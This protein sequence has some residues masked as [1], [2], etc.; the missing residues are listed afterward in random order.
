MG[1]D[2]LLDQQRLERADARGGRRLVAVGDRRVVV[3]VVVRGRSLRLLE[4]VLEDVDEEPVV[5]VAG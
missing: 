1:D 4:P 2:A 3:V 5:G